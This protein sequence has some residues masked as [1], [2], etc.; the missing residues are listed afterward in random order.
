MAVSHVWCG[1]I[2][3]ASIAL[4]YCLAVAVHG[5]TRFSLLRVLKSH[6]KNMKCKYCIRLKSLS[7]LLQFIGI[8]QHEIYHI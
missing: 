4:S 1:H 2:R 7:T 3:C 6:K 8:S 5:A